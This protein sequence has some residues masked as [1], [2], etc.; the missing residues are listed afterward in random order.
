M[1]DVSA[2]AKPLPGLIDDVYHAALLRN[3]EAVVRDANIPVD[4]LYKSMVGRCSAAEID[5]VKG[6]RRH[7]EHG[8]YGLL[9]AGVKPTV[10]PLER[11]SAM[12]AACLRNYIGARVMTLQDTLAALSDHVMPTP[13]VLL[14]PNF[15]VGVDGGLPAKWMVPELLGLLYARQSAGLQTVIYVQDVKHMAAAYGTACEQHVCSEHFVKADASKPVK[16]S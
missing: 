9:L 2:V 16:K 1:T 10:S 15:F 8:I 6:L 7:A 14:I 12:A 3:A 13:T 5:Y 4:M 11:F